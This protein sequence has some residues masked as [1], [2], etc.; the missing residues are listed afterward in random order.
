MGSLIL[1]DC[2][3][4]PTMTIVLQADTSGPSSGG[5]G[6]DGGRGLNTGFLPLPVSSLECPGN[7]RLLILPYNLAIT[8][9]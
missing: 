6:L 5:Q 9:K 1:A 3:P 7:G 8:L 4:K 2:R